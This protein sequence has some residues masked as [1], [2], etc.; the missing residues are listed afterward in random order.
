ML[1]SNLCQFFE[2]IGAQYYSTGAIVPLTNDTSLKIPLNM[3]G[4][5]VIPAYEFQHSGKVTHWDLEAI[6][7]GFI[8][9]QVR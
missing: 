3:A 4:S 9:L 5:V 7:V 6:R 8:T 2:I 1:I